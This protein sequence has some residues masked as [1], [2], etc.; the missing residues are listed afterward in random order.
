MC[1][2]LMQVGIAGIGK[3]GQN[4]LR[5]LESNKAF[6][7]K[8]IFDL[9]KD[10]SFKYPL[11][12]NID[13]FLDNKLDIVIIATPT[14]THLEVAR[15]V[16]KRVKIVLVEKPLALNLDEMLEMKSLAKKY[17]VSVAVG[18]VERFNPII[19]YLKNMLDLN[20]IISIDIKRFSPYPSRISDCGILQDLGVHDID[21][22][23]FLS[24]KN[25]IK[26]NIKTCFINDKNREDEA[27]ISCELEGGIIA[28]IH[29]SWNSYD[30]QR[31]LVIITKSA[32]YE[33]DLA[34]F[35]LLKNKENIALQVSS[36]LSLEHKALLNLAINN[37]F[38][39]LANIDSAIAIQKVLES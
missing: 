6:N 23:Q 25:I 39:T 26:S 7:I 12:N 38:S 17:N 10:S 11:F 5:E 21:L 33:A 20:E 31:S 30:R 3:M 34:N 4:H 29:Q 22:L 14:S 1:N 13:E 32:T 28:N 9:H 18:L 24:S 8:A 16:F 19:I 35:T 36:P 27:I 15:E 37:D 2:K